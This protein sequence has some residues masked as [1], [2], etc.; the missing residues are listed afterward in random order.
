MYQEHRYQ[1]LQA[2]LDQ[3]QQFR[4]AGQRVMLADDPKLRRFGFVV[5]RNL[6]YITLSDVK[7]SPVAL[8]KTVAEHLSRR[9]VVEGD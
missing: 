8:Q 6:Y 7:G 4:Q 2:W 1:D 9:A 5:G 3:A